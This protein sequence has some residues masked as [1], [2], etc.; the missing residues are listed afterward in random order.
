MSGKGSCRV[1][2]LLLALTVQVVVAQVPFQKLSAPGRARVRCDGGLV[3]AC[4]VRGAACGGEGSGGS[5][6]PQGRQ[7]KAVRATL[8]SLCP[9]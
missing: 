3:A 1:L 5:R 7:Q 8:R 2:A 9:P 6:A 4:L